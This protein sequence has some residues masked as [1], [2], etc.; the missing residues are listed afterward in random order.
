M[1]DAR[2]PAG[3]TLQQ[4]RDV[5][6]DREAVPLHTGRT[7]RW[8]DSPEA[9]GEVIRPAIV[10]GFHTLCLVQ[11]ADDTDWY[12]GSLNDDGSIICWSNYGENLFEALRGL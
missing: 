2:L 9:A 12:M 8:Y 5:S 1:A 10:L 3:W 6:G 7:V 11:S 4:I